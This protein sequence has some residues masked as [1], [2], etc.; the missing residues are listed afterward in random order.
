M[1]QTLVWEE[2]PLSQTKPLNLKASTGEYDLF[3]E[4]CSRLGYDNFK[5][6]KIKK[7]NQA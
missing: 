5:F 2:N 6:K 7:Q 1:T 4:L 3:I